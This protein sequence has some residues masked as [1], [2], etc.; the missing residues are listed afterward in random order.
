MRRACWRCKAQRGRPSPG[1]GWRR[2]GWRTPRAGAAT[3]AQVALQRRVQQRGHAFEAPERLDSRGL[4]AGGP[5]GAGERLRRRLVAR[6]HQDAR[7]ALGRPR[8]LAVALTV[9]PVVEASG[10]RATATFR[11]HHIA[12]SAVRPWMCIPLPGGLGS[13]CRRGCHAKLHK[14]PRCPEVVLVLRGQVSV[15]PAAIRCVAANLPRLATPILLLR[16]ASPL[17]V[18]RVLS[19][20]GALSLGQAV[21]LPH[22]TD[23]STQPTASSQPVLAAQQRNWA[24]AR[25]RR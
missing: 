8:H 16:H 15:V 9:Q 5:R 20:R 24:G 14:V 13:C 12:S 1:C 6:A 4:A 10:G 2:R 25:L 19:E 21:R 11:F 3:A 7:D 22:G 18:Q 23:G 17:K